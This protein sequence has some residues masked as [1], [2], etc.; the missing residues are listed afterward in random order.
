MIEQIYM[1]E[2]VENNWDIATCMVNINCQNSYTY[3]QVLTKRLNE[4][5]C[6]GPNPIVTNDD[7]N[8]CVVTCVV[9][10]WTICMYDFV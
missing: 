7:I 9:E 6:L 5:V 10:D 8:W 3:K 2:F 1:C 4:F